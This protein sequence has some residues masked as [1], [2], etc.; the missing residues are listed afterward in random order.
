MRNQKRSWRWGNSRKHCK[1][2]GR[3]HVILMKPR[4][5]AK[6]ASRKLWRLPSFASRRR[7][8]LAQRLQVVCSP[9]KRQQR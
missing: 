7:F 8:C 4:D 5:V 9:W 3:A 1:D 2:S 6:Y